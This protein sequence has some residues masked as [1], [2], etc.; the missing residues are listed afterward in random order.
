MS[1]NMFMAGST[2]VLNAVALTLTSLCSDH[3][4]AQ[5]IMA[6][7]SLISPFLA[8]WLLKV[9]IRS[10]DPPELTRTI[11]GLNASISTCEKHLKDTTASQ[12]FLDQTRKQLESFRSKLQNARVDFEK[13]RVHSITQFQIPPPESSD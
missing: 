8:I 2:T 12:E 5:V 6:V 1:N 7:C 11:S 4:V 10:D 9:Y 13:N 3:N